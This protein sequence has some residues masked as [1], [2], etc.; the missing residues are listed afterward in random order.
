[1]LHASL[2]EVQQHPGI[3]RPIAR[4]CYRRIV[5]GLLRH[6]HKAPVQDPGQWAVPQHRPMNRREHL[7][8]RVVA[9]DVRPLM[10]QHRFQLRA[11]PLT[12]IDR[13]HDG[14]ARDSQRHRRRQEVRL[15]NL[16]S[17]RHLPGCAAAPE[18]TPAHCEAGRQAQKKRA[19]HQRVEHPRGAHPREHRRHPGDF[20]ER[21]SAGSRASGRFRRLRGLIGQRGNLRWLGCLVSPSDGHLGQS[22]GDHGH[23]Q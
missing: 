6:L 3:R 10:R 22:G 18:Q 21:R 14:G 20:V 9:A 5:A 23:R 12:P 15:A 2:H 4:R 1:M 11:V 8:Q 16:D 7:H 19:G 13:Q 17:L